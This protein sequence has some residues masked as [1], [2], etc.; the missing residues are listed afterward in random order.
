MEVKKNFNSKTI[1]L[2]HQENHINVIFVKKFVKYNRNLLF[3]IKLFNAGQKIHKC[4]ACGKSFSRSGHL[5]IHIS[6]VHEYRKG[7]KYVSL[8]INYLLKQEI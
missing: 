1:I 7:Y 8:A 5:K 4:N 2:N 3:I 6:A